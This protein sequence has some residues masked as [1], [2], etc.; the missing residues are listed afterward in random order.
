[1]VFNDSEVT[2]EIDI[3]NTDEQLFNQ[4]VDSLND[5]L[6][7]YSET[8]VTL[9]GK[10]RGRIKLYD[11]GDFYNSFK[12]RATR[13]S[14]IIEADTEKEDTDL[15]EVYGIEIL[16]LTDLSLSRLLEITVPKYINY[17]INEVF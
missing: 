8:S 6:P 4:G 11:E 12:I 14:I 5:P 13:N 7:E 16:G 3:L 15:A 10:P 17:V 2:R 1:M 9:Y